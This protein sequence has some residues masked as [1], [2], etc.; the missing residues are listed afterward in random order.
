MTSVG[1]MQPYFLPYVGY[2][3]LINAVDT[4]II[5]DRVKYTKKGW[6]NRNRLL[7]SDNRLKSISINLVKSKD[8]D[9]ILEK[10]ISNVYDR[11]KLVRI[12]KETYRQAPYF[13]EI[14]AFIEEVILFNTTSLSNYLEN[15]IM[16][17]SRLL[18]IDTA[19]CLARRINHDRNLMGSK[20]VMDLVKGVGGTTYI[21]MI[22]GAHLYSK[23]E[24]N[25]NELELLFITQD[26]ECT[27]PDSRNNSDLSYS[28]V[29]LISYRGL[30]YT[31]SKV[32]GLI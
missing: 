13:Y 25:K 17:F 32:K 24:F 28:I 20:L 19:I 16:T 9:T 3:Q 15:S 6:I 22:G 21:N 10:E 29:D 5:H 18:E 27:E 14:E 8:T 26:I 12:I 4:F 1:I 2:Y 31:I 23:S 30:D 11:E 7:T